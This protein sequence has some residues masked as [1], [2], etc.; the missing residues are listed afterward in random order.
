M[1][2][3]V[4]ITV[5][6]T[7]ETVSLAVAGGDAVSLAVSAPAETVA[8]TVEPE[9]DAVGLAVAETVEQVSVAVAPAGET[10]AV[11]IADQGDTVTLV[12]GETEGELAWNDL[13]TRWDVAPAQTA[14]IA[15]GSV[16]AYQLD[17]VTRYRLVTSPYTPAGD[18]FYATFTGGVL[19]DLVAARG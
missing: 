18:A 17:G 2:E 5:A 4:E 1:S 16:F 19:S 13:A 10:V 11:A 3:A 12:V 6:T 8:I 14:T 9:A 7:V 15:A